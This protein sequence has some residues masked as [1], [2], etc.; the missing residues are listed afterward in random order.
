MQRDLVLVGIGEHHLGKTPMSSIGL[1]SCVGLVIHDRDKRI[2]V[3]A[4]VM[5]PL[6]QGKQERPGKYADSAV[7]IMISELVKAGSNPYS[8]V[9][10]IAGGASMF[11]SFS[12]NLNIGERNV[13][14]LRKLLKERNIAIV[15]EDV[16]G[17]MGRTIIYIP[18]E[19]GKVIVRK[20]NNI[21]IEI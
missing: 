17:D 21:I 12:G 14:A 15:G 1:G 5:L 13:D 6:S 3:L 11:K 19:K 20:G 9:A 10:K 7:E 16:G 2:G 18:S 4:H 8:L